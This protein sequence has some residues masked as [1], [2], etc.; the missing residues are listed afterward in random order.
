MLTSVSAIVVTEFLSARLGCLALAPLVLLGIY[1]VLDWARS[2]SAGAGDLRL[3]LAVQFY[4]VLAMPF[5]MHL[6]RSRYTHAWTLVLLWTLYAAAKVAE[7]CD[8][9][10]FEWGG[11]WSGHTVKHLVAAAASYSLLH[12]LRHRHLAAGPAVRHVMRRGQ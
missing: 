11:V 8:R 10:V 6:F 12:G 7:L 2:E 3:Y 1:S 9:S 5:V 4:P